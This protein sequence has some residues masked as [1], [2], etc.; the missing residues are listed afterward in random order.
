MTARASASR[1]SPPDHPARD[2]S[3]NSSRNV[4]QQDRQWL[5]KRATD[6]QG[7]QKRTVQTKMTTFITDKPST[8]SSS[9]YRAPNHEP[10]DADVFE[11]SVQFVKTRRSGD[12]P[13]EKLD[14]TE[15]RLDVPLRA[16]VVSSTRPQPQRKKRKSDEI[17][18]SSDFAEKAI[19]SD[20]NHLDSRLKA[21]KRYKL[22]HDGQDLPSD[23]RMVT[24]SLTSLSKDPSSEL[25]IDEAI[26]K[27]GLKVVRGRGRTTAMNVIYSSDA[28]EAAA[29]ERHIDTNEM[30]AGQ[31]NTDSVV[32]ENQAQIDR[33]PPSTP[34]SI[35]PDSQSG[36][37]HESQPWYYHLQAARYQPDPM[38]EPVQAL[39]YRSSGI[40]LRTEPPAIEEHL[41]IAD[42]D[43]PA[44]PGPPAISRPVR[45]TS[46]DAQDADN[47]LDK[48]PS[49]RPLASEESRTH[50]EKHTTRD[51]NIESLVSNN[52][53]EGIGSELSQRT[54]NDSEHASLSQ[55]RKLAARKEKY[56]LLLPSLTDDDF[57]VALAGN[58]Q[59]DTESAA[60]SLQHDGGHS[61][62]NV[63]SQYSETFDFGRTMRRMLPP[64]VENN[65]VT[66]QPQ[67]QKTVVPGRD[68][69]GVEN[70]AVE[71]EEPEASIPPLPLPHSST[72]LVES[73]R[74]LLPQQGIL[75][76][77]VNSKV[78]STNTLPEEEEN[79][80]QTETMLPLTLDT[81]LH[82]PGILSPDFQLRIKP[83]RQY[84]AVLQTVAKD[85]ITPKK[86]QRFATQLITPGKQLSSYMTSPEAATR[87]PR[88]RM[89]PNPDYKSPES[90]IENVETLATWS[91]AK[92]ETLRSM[93]VGQGKWDMV[94]EEKENQPLQTKPIESAGSHA[95]QSLDEVVSPHVP[96]KFA[97]T[98]NLDL[99]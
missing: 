8:H 41:L 69:D 32:N 97:R 53:T 62:G 31:R 11:E 56:K 27:S 4:D 29:E 9:V 89:I 61:N 82:R 64:P 52:N 92:Y 95:P 17:D 34:S 25:D 51:R 73:I 45:T 28:D 12:Y 99:D 42:A 74:G 76:P 72:N 86:R 26:T 98:E 96:A 18:N 5:K 71:A 94:D 75:K 19:S 16:N 48:R 14:D 15:L 59:P 66:A 23:D 21:L 54:E 36:Y 88:Q 81:Q 39:N 84:P 10:L 6:N 93:N 79:S 57:E 67:A 46:A 22:Q 30:V 77:I 78:Q 63:S 20:S 38:L 33:L 83:S 70:Q 1:S 37:Y 24:S 50:I 80:Y 49:F 68:D 65:R 91:P 40:P 13:F 55:Q 58:A 7:T 35:V 43:H 85:P 47:L 2:T 44:I 3:K 90:M 60:L 87:T